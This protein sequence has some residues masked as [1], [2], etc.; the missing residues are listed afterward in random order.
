[1]AHHLTKNDFYV[2]PRNLTQYHDHLNAKIGTMDATS[3]KNAGFSTATMDAQTAPMSGYNTG[4]L[5]QFLQNW[6]PGNIRMF[7][8][9]RRSEELLG[10]VQAGSFAD[11][12]IVAKFTEM[13]GFTQN[14]GDLA[15][16]PRAGYNIEYLTR[17]I[18]RFQGGVQTDNLESQRMAKIGFSDMDEKR[19]SLARAFAVTENYV[20][21][22]GWQG[23]RCF[24]L[25]NDPNLSAYVTVAAT[26]TGASP[27]WSTKTTELQRLDI[28]ADVSRLFKQTK[29]AFNPRKEQFTWA[30]PTDVSMAL[31]NLLTIGGTSIAMTL[32]D[33][34]LKQYPGI[35]IVVI[36]EFDLANG[37]ANVWYMYK[38]RTVDVDD[39]TDDGNTIIN[40]IQN[41]MFML[42]SL[43]TKS[44][45]SMENYA[46]AQ[47]GTFVKRP[48][49]V[50][51]SS[52]M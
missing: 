52:G 19:A 17:Q 43:P 20:A 28:Q 10:F 41:R 33:W 22:N 49:L 4:V 29:T 34:V 40:M 24:G 45:G 13:F 47:A 50:V 37:G 14:Y 18:V 27:L 51:R 8:A 7:T 3:L 9:P 23:V 15:D 11:E 21:F 16:V 2:N 5:N 6:L 1:M 42:S 25:L 44:G 35:R 46:S 38:E 12:T 31:N 36:P 32:E 48:I 39:S 26:G 30:I